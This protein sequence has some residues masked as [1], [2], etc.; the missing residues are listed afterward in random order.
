MEDQHLHDV[1]VPPALP[2][3]VIDVSRS[4]RLDEAV[5]LVESNCLPPRNIPYIA[6]SYRWGNT[7]K[8]T[9][10][11]KTLQDH[12]RCISFS[13]MPRTLQDAV[14]VT[15][16]LGLRFLWV[17]ALCIVQ[18]D[19]SDWLQEAGNM[20][21]IYMHSYCTIAAHAA[22]HA[23]HGFLEQALATPR[24]VQVGQLLITQGSD[25]K[26]H[27]EESDLSKRGWVLQERLL[28]PRIVHF[29]NDGAIYF[30]SGAGFHL[31]QDRFDATHNHHLRS[32]G[33]RSMVQH[34]IRG[35]QEILDSVT[36]LAISDQIYYD[37]YDIVQHY[38]RC[39]LTRPGDKLP[40]LTG[41]IRQ[42][43][44]FTK[45]K[46]YMGVWQSKVPYCLLWLREKETLE[47]PPG[48]RAPSWS[49]AAY[50]GEI[51]FLAWRRYGHDKTLVPEFS[52][53]I[54]HPSA[55]PED[56]AAGILAGPMSMVIWDVKMI[57]NIS[58]PAG[59]PEGGSGLRFMEGQIG[60][61]GWIQSFNWEPHKM[62]TRFWAVHDDHGK[63]IGWASLDRE[64]SVEIDGEQHHITCIAV[65]SYTDD[66][67]AT[68]LVRGYLV[69]FIQML[70]TGVW[71][72]VGMGQIDQAEWFKTMEPTNV[73]LI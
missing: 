44:T 20:G 13:E 54:F 48:Y 6:L 62:E 72:R 15:R 70:A 47:A 35:D 43:Q 14:I 33:I 61:P 58:C 12:K 24:M 21:N 38:S 68:G 36:R 9:T 67:P 59:H 66:N 55:R 29:A 56:E 37:W 5:R 10:T 22:Q 51:Q 60:R 23:D 2:T 31:V 11:I 1:K 3:R 63:R 41:I 71:V 49:W 27:I 19:K 64:E 52:E 8:L 16:R 26:L 73:V 34:L 30:E 45:D 17:D 53:A 25:K 57:R 28:S 18:D 39:S 50:D 4:A 7:N 65:A 40:A 42:I 69:L 32:P 46:C